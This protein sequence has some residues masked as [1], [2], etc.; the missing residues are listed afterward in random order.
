M[1]VTLPHVLYRQGFVLYTVFFHK[2]NLSDSLNLLKSRR[3]RCRYS[4]SMSSKQARNWV[5]FPRARHSLMENWTWNP[6]CWLWICWQGQSMVAL[7]YHTVPRPL[8]TPAFYADVPTVC[9]VGDEEIKEGCP[10]NLRPSN[11]Q[12]QFWEAEWPRASQ[13][14]PFAPDAR[15]RICTPSSQNLF[16]SSASI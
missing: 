5:L 4:H 1:T 2:Q 16:L 7:C 3:E 10:T 13:H 6:V 9:F 8:W 14:W 11:Y 15:A 12:G